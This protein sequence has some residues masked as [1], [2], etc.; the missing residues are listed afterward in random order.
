MEAD[1]YLYMIIGEYR[2]PNIH[3][4][5]SRLTD[6]KQLIREWAHKNLEGIYL[7]GSCAKKTALKGNSDCDL[8]ISLY[9]DTTESLHDI[10][11]LLFKQFKYAGYSVRKQNVSIRAKINGLEIDLVPGRIQRG[12]SNN[13][14]LYVSK[15]KSWVKTN[16]HQHLDLVERRGRQDE[17]LATKIWRTCHKL[18]FPSIYIELVVMRVLKGKRKEHIE[19]NF[20]AVLEFLSSDFIYEKVVDPSNKNNVISDLITERQKKAIQK[21]AEQCLYKQNWNAV[22]W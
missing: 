13:H 18:K 2:A 1:E 6:V 9:S 17:I 19:K 16:I 8:F 11:L 15:E 5:D 12:E 14:S 10:H 22:I 7:F 21:K 4:R 20:N 3:I